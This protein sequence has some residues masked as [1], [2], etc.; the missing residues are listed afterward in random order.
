MV[1]IREIS[2]MLAYLAEIDTFIQPSEITV[3]AWH[4]ILDPTME[5]G[6]A[7]EYIVRHYRKPDARKI[8][9]GQINEAWH[10]RPNRVGKS[11]TTCGSADHYYDHEAVE[12]NNAYLQ[13]RAALGHD[14]GGVLSGIE[15]ASKKAIA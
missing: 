1:N 14:L 12:P 7:K 4:D 15:A 5:S 8:T 9:P 11:C 13:A 6:W 2:A 3:K 10:N